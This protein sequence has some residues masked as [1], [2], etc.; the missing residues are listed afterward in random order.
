MV[1]FLR[2]RNRVRFDILGLRS[3]ARHRGVHV[4][5]GA[6]EEVRQCHSLERSVRAHRVYITARSHSHVHPHEHL[7]SYLIVLYHHDVGSLR[8]EF[9]HP[10]AHLLARDQGLLLK[11]VLRVLRKLQSRS[12]RSV[13]RRFASVP[14]EIRPLRTDHHVRV[15]SLKCSELGPWQPWN[16]HLGFSVAVLVRS[17]IVLVQQ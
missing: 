16:V 5:L 9:L 17:L 10:D 13:Q 14:V 7:R 12:P 8:V 6:L 2:L 3:L 1:L 4:W 15:R 11:R